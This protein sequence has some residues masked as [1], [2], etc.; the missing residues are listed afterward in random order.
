MWSFLPRCLPIALHFGLD[1]GVGA[2]IRCPADLQ[3]R[4]CGIQE[5]FGVFDSLHLNNFPCVDGRERMSVIVRALGIR[6]NQF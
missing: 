4:A 3:V 2:S 6:R 5:R 1:L